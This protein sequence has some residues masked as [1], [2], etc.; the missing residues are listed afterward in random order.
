V[1]DRRPDAA[2]LVRRDR[3]ADARPA[4][5]DPAVRSTLLD[6]LAQPLREVRVV[7]LGVRPVPAEVDQ[8]V[9]ARGQDLEPADDLVLEPRTGVVGGEDNSH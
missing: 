5:Q 9:L 7:V 6:R 2:H 8:F 1:A 3:R 4:D